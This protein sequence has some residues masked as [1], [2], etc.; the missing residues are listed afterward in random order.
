MLT[1]LPV[2]RET[3]FYRIRLPKPL[4]PKEHL[5]IGVTFSCILTIN[6]KPKSIPQ[7]EDQFVEYQFSAY[8]L[9][10][11][12]T[13]KQKTEVKFPSTNIPEYTVIQKTKNNPELPTRS[14]S[15][16]TYGPFG[17]VSPGALAPVKVRYQFNKP[18][19][20]IS[21]LERD[22][23]ISHW[24][25]NAAFE[26][27]YTLI[28][29]AANLSKPF[30]RVEWSNT[31]YY[32]KKT[33]AIKDLKVSLKAGCKSPYFVDIIGNVS[34][35]RFRSNKHEASLEIRPRYPVFGGWKYP[36]RIGWDLDL[37]YYLR[38]LESDDRFVLN[39]PFF[40]GLKQ[41]EGVE[42]ELVKLRVLLPEGAK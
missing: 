21:K 19:I 14:G 12:T 10:S 26:E 2:H 34:T 22:I 16:L 37:K 1:H 28:N 27:R 33:R 20:H 39:V 15:R 23:E 17:E 4:A 9:S 29:R 8:A 30:S 31:N 18:I 13:L 11:Y 3:Q 38:K 25:G 36:F 24:G 6:P 32:N 42:Y 41:A 5:S 40:D 35:S 7:N